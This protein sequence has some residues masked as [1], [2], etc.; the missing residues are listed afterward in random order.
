MIK[1]PTLFSQALIGVTLGLGLVSIKGV[2]EGVICKHGHQCDIDIGAA[3]L[4]HD[5]N[6]SNISS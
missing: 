6:R 2:D 1:P 4:G 3:M 5:V